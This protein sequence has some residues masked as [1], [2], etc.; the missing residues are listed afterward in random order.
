[1]HGTLSAIALSVTTSCIA[2]REVAIDDFVNRASGLI[3]P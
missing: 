1:M 3:N 2:R